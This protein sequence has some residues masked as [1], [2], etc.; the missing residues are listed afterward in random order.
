MAIDNKDVRQVLRHR[1][2]RGITQHQPGDLTENTVWTRL[3]Y[4]LK[5]MRREGVRLSEDER[6]AVASAVLAD[7]MGLGPLQPFMDDP[8]VT[9][10]MVNGPSAVFVEK[11]GQKY[12]T[13]ARFDNDQHLRNTVEKILR[14]T[15]KRLDESS[16]YVDA[17][18]PD[19][20]RIN[21]VIPPVVSNGPHL[22]VRKYMRSIKTV[23][24]FIRLGTLDGRIGQFLYACIRAR[25][26]I[27]FA[28]ATGSGKTT[29]M[30]V[31]ATH[32]GQ[33]ERIV[34]IEDT[35]ELHFHQPN[36]VRLLTRP[37]NVEG[38]GE[39]TIRELFRNSLRMRPNRIILGEIRGEEAFDY[40]QALISGHRGSLAVIHASSPEETVSRLENLVMQSGVNVPT[41]AIRNQITYGLDLIVQVV[42]LDDGSRKASRISEVLDVDDHG[43]VKLRDVF[44]FREDGLDPNGKVVGQFAATGAIPSFFPRFRLAG[45][46]VHEA[47]FRP[48]PAA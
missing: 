13:Q 44:Y 12:L 32:F 24:D 35:P 38:K 5:E 23:D 46:Q 47:I 37:S 33:H 9:E 27:L 14:D 22:T 18:M 6:D 45:V 39:V 3:Q 16:P 20:S 19:G 48:P 8:E 36:T 26:N 4:L 10:I 42:Q 30:E 2:F 43:H 7:I 17:S 25:M 34:V 28:G 11:A 41:E 31:F 1:F 29:M 40:L 15:G 21:V